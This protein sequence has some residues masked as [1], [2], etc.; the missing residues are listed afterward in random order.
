MKPAG[1]TTYDE[2]KAH[3]EGRSV[4][5]WQR[6]TDGAARFTLIRAA[7]LFDGRGE[8]LLEEA[9]VLLEGATI[10]ALG[11]AHEVRA[12][13]GADAAVFEYPQATLLPGLIDAHTHLNGFGDG[14]PGDQLAD[15]PD[16]I[17]LL[18][19]ARNARAHLMSGVTTLRD[20]GSKGQT[21]FALRRAAAMGIVE[22]P[23]M[24]LCGRPITITGGHTW[25][26]GGEADGVDGVRHAVRQLVKEG[27]DFI[28]IMATGG[29]TRTSYPTRPAFN[30][31]EVRAAV[32]EAHKFGKPV[33]AHCTS[34]QG[35]VNA[36][37]A[38]VDTII[39]CV[40]A[41]ADG[42][43]TFRPEVAERIAAAGC[44][45]D[46]TI[47]QSAQRVRLL[48]E[49][50][51]GG[52][53]LTAA[54]EHELDRLRRLH[55][56]RQEHFRRLLAMGVKMVSGSDSAWMWYPMGRF[57]DEI[58]GHAEWG[59]SSAAAILSATRDGA[60]CLG[61]EAHTG[62]IEPGKA[63]DLVV[64]DGDPLRDVR[65]LLRVREVFLAGS[66]VP[67]LPPHPAA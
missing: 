2:E 53:P 18:Q 23:R 9:A 14:R 11:A 60:A 57:A 50:Q 52:R 58:I 29:S 16:E 44:W 19:S 28:K 8:G 34:T 31:D 3:E 21:S 46:A 33:A 41:D 22:A 59:M 20:C 26:F 13:D 51:E 67:R 65:A 64:V 43:P 49:R 54:E 30:A 5:G 47:A 45:V 38:G 25:Y 24:V 7:R 17:L 4:E 66:R 15:V 12:P 61:L 36:V 35:I 56:V 27:A 32:E 55:D 48:Q 10:R 40:F 42:T 37:E 1:S 39:H 62:T 6:M 63:A